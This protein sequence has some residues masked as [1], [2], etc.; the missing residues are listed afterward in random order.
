MNI[1]LN[2]T[3]KKIQDIE[4][5]DYVQSF[6]TSTRILEPKQVS[7]TMLPV[8]KKDEQRKILFTTGYVVN[9]YKHPMLVFRNDVP[10]Y[11]KTDNLQ[12]GDICVDAE[13]NKRNIVDITSADYDEHFYD[14]EVQDNH[15]FFA[16]FENTY[17]GHNSSNNNYPWFHYEA[18]LIM[19][20]GNA[21]G[22]EDTRVRHADHT[23][24]FSHLA[25]ERMLKGE[26]LTLFH[27]NV[28][29]ELWNNMGDYDKF[30]EHYKHYEKTVPKKNKKTIPA[31]DYLNLFLNE[32]FLQ[33]RLYYSFA[34]NINTGPW[35]QHD[36]IT[37]L[38][39]EV[40]SKQT[41]LDGSE[42]IPEVAVCILAGINHG[43]TTD[44]RIPVLSEYLVRF[45]DAMI[46]YMDYSHD[47][48]EYAAKKRRTLGIGDSDI[49]HF[50]AKNKKFYNTTDGR[51]LFHERMELTAFHTYKASMQLAK[52]Y[53]PCELIADTKWDDA[54]LP[55]DSYNKNTDELI[56]VE[57]K[58]DWEWLREEIRINGMRNS[59]LKANAPFGNSAKPSNSTSGIEPPRFLATVKEDKNFK[60][61]Q[62]VPEFSKYKHYYT[63]AWGDDFNNVDYFKFVSLLQKF[64]D[65]SMSTNQYSNLIRYNGKIPLKVLKQE[66]LTAYKFGLKTMY[67]QVFRSD[68]DIDGLAEEETQG[69]GSGGCTV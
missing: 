44:E 25:I 69:C 27:M 1:K 40:L 42:G 67:Y 64:T 4:V 31:S 12:I 46:D 55:I 3:K 22:T 58:Q 49:F 61:T 7:D 17:C 19:Q 52:E 41:A 56:S 38:C 35:K 59:T 43:H 45:L 28:V 60:A 53:G 34:D 5:G 23:I 6:N 9:S 57:L 36:Y 47:E 39:C 15:N 20:L 21:K 2:Y 54:W 11:V 24:I 62:L 37:N 66:F 10:M 13:G 14:L 65:Q 32:R 8:V 16:G 68:D 51:N 26:D 29:P 50:L 18:E 48:I 63:T 33:G 30:K